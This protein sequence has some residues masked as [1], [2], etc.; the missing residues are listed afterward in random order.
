VTQALEQGQAAR[1]WLSPQVH[2]VGVEADLVLLDIAS[3]AYFCLADAVQY[4]RLGPGG[5]IEAHPP[6]A[7]EDLLQ[8]GL[9]VTVSDGVER[10]RPPPIRRG[11]S[12]A[13]P[14]VSPSAM[15][16][17]LAANLEAAHALQH[18]SFAEILALA[19]PLSSEGLVA[20]SA[21][22]ITEASRFARMAPWLP[23]SGLCLMRSLQQRLYLQR[24]G[25]AA[26]W[27]FGVRTWPFEAHCWLQAG[28]LVLDD[29]PEH[30]GAY[31]P[32]L[33]V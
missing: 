17:A 8:A 24:R 11:L 5:A 20:P 9:L 1:L 23:R 18:L 7:A 22:L 2:A 28:D 6:Q 16:A 14:S 10:N 13:P 33:V 3:D 31:T 27:V 4:L 15:S 32:I 29:T 19:G 30:A 12:L 25:L 26:A 21:A